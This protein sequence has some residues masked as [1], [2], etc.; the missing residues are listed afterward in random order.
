MYGNFSA[1]AD[2]YQFSM[3][4]EALKLTAFK[5]KF[6]VSQFHANADLVYS[7]NNQ[8]RVEMELVSG[9]RLEG[10]LMDS[11][12]SNRSRAVDHLNRAGR[13]AKPVAIIGTRD[14][15]RYLIARLTPEF[16]A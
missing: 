13:F 1:G 6:D 8:H 11:S 9:M 14:A 16:D 15:V 4:S 3:S 5:Y 7:P 10:S 12:P 2:N